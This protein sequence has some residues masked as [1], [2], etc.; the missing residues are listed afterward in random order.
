M[1]RT[2]EQINARAATLRDNYSKTIAAIDNDTS[3]SD[4]GKQQRLAETYLDTRKELTALR[5]E[6]EGEVTAKRNSLEQQ[7]FGLPAPSSADRILSWRDAEDRASTLDTVEHAEALM[8]RALRG[9]DRILANAVAGKAWS[10]AGGI[11]TEAAREWGI[12]VLDPWLATR[13]EAEDLL[14]DL[15]DITDVSNS[16]KVATNFAFNIAKPRLLA[17]TSDVQLM[18]LAEGVTTP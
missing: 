12:R 18:Q 17:T 16:T 5:R 3:L 14:R 10:I 6:L 9:S 11:Q 2:P 7:L 15:L 1:A 4:L 8:Q 13:P